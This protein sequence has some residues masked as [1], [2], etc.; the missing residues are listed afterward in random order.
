MKTG[1]SFSPGGLLLP[2]HVGVMGALEYNQVLTP[3]TPIAGSSAGAIACAS[4]ASRVPSTQVLEATIAI[5]DRCEQLGGAR[6][7][8]LPLLKEKLDE[9]L[10]DERF[11]DAQAR[12]GILALVIY[13]KL[14]SPT[15]ESLLVQFVIHLCF[16]SLQPIILSFWTRRRVSLACS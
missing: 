6:G 3:E 1:F 7:N 2:Y 15:V 12:P 10:T 4:H 8:L 16:R 5:S 13:Y 11:E 14:N 9:L